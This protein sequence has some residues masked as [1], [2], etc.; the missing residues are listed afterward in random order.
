M[1]KNT[2]EYNDYVVKDQNENMLKNRMSGVSKGTPEYQ[3][4]RKKL[5]D[6]M[7]ANRGVCWNNKGI[8][9]INSLIFSKYIMKRIRIVKVLDG[10]YIY[11]IK[12][13]HYEQVSIDV[14]ASFIMSVMSEYDESC[15]VSLREDELLNLI[16][17]KVK[18]M[19]QL[20]E[21][22]GYI[23]MNNGT[24]KITNHAFKPKFNR[25]IFNLSSLDFSYD[26]TAKCTKFVEFLEDIF[27][28]N[29]KL[30]KLMQQ[31]FGYTFSYGDVKM[32]KLFYFYGAG[33]NGKGVLAKIL[34]D[35]HGKQ[36]VSA[37]FL[38]E[39]SN[40]FSTSNLVGKVL[41]I[42]PE[43]KQSLLLDTA[44]IKS[45]TA[46]DSVM[47]EK[48]YQNAYSAKL[49]TKFIVL[50]NYAL[51][52]DDDSYG[53]LERIVPIPFLKKYTE[54]PYDGIRK[55]GVSYQDPHLYEKLK[56]ELPGIFNWAME[57]L[58]DLQEHDW[59]LTECTEVKEL[60]QQF[61]LQNK[62]VRLFFRSCIEV[63]SEDVAIKS[64]DITNAF[65]RWTRNNNIPSLGFGNAAE[66][67]QEFRKVMEQ[68]G[69]SSTT[70][71]R[72]GYDHYY[73]I[74][75]KENYAS[76]VSYNDI[77]CKEKLNE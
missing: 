47:I 35:L 67:H 66:F 6:M 60:R 25:C 39:L 11:N 55:E 53:F 17:R 58:R 29:K 26:P 71:K 51:R 77:I 14:V 20:E 73:G 9:Y 70:K 12:E 15:Y 21:T 74:R 22:S 3:K 44:L 1:I 50:S 2:Y 24:Y 54:L 7:I 34:T 33:R 37:I 41:N 61:A 27:D 68:E 18:N 19:K 52:T 43:G 16:F 62:P 56:E 8:I 5:Q 57:G 75:L 23:V 36:N 38:D 32:H 30:I 31:I 63:V 65:N 4:L 49:S 10:I 13:H 69:L 45:L 40:R 46:G 64:S 59:A 42:S 72:K 76:I 48:K 28:H